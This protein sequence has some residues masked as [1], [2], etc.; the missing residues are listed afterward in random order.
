MGKLDIIYGSII[1]DIAGSTLERKYPENEDLDIEDLIDK[2]HYT[3]DTV[4][5][6]AFLDAIKNNKSVKDSFK[7]WGTKYISQGFS[8]SFIK[9]FLEVEEYTPCH[10]GTNGALM[11]LSPAIQFNDLPLERIYEAVKVTHDCFEAYVCAEWYVNFGRNIKGETSLKLMQQCPVKNF[12]T[13]YDVLKTQRH[14]DMSSI[15]TLRNALVCY[16]SSSSFIETLQKSLY[17]GGDTDT[18][19][20]VSCAL[21]AA[22]FDVPKNLIEKVNKKLSIE[23]IDLLNK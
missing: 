11:M 13:T 21:A 18:V 16:T 15:I 9:N 5:T 19:S 23:M 22:D 2:G 4:L 3:D 14:W 1:G 7:E 20:C 17:L 12:I 10:S 6:L 8:K